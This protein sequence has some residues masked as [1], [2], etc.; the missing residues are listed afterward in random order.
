MQLNGTN[1][2]KEWQASSL[3]L[4]FRWM[5]QSTFLIGLEDS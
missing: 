3:S 4:E 2:Q 1:A 5:S